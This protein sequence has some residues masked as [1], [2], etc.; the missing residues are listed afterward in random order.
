MRHYTEQA[1]SRLRACLEVHYLDSSEACDDL[2]NDQF[3]LPGVMS[4]DET[5]TAVS[6]WVCQCHVLADAMS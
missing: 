2:R 1:A 6:R 4:I 5:L 3:R